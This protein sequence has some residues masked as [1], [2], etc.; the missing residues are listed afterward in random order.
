MSLP[1]IL[2]FALFAFVS[3]ITPGPNNLMLLASGASF[4]LRRTVPHMLGVAVGFGAMLLALGAGLAELYRALP[5]AQLAL[6]IAGSAY[7]L[8]LAW[9]IATARPDIDPSKSTG[10]PFRFIE[11]AAFQ[12]VNPKAW[13]MALTALA[14]YAGGGDWAAVL[15][16]AA[17]F[18]A[19]NLPCVLSWAALGTGMARVLGDPVA[20]RR[21]NLALAA[22]LVL[23]LIPILRA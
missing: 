15:A 13:T 9:R 4:G 14:V 12:W 6:K 21:I 16:V 22:L 1:D 8:W 11:A 17:I 18:T 10:R 7:L 23:S 5:W 2:A 20:V 3:S 19:I